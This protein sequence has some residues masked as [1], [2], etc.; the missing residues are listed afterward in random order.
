MSTTTTNGAPAPDAASDAAA[1][2]PTIV[3]AEDTVAAAKAAYA[4]L[5]AAE[6]DAADATSDIGAA[7][8]RAL[9]EG[10][11]VVLAPGRAARKLSIRNFESATGISRSTIAR[12]ARLAA[13]REAVPGIAWTVRD[14]DSIPADAFDKGS[15]RLTAKAAAEAGQFRTGPDAVKALRGVRA[16]RSDSTPEAK[17]SKQ[18]KTAAL[19]AIAAGTADAVRDT[20]A[21]AAKQASAIAEAVGIDG[22]A[23]DAA[24]AE[25]RESRAVLA[26]ATGST[27]PDGF[28]AA[29]EAIVKRAEAGWEFDNGSDEAR[30]WAAATAKAKRAVTRLAA[31]AKAFAEAKR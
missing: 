3:G 17:A 7:Y 19:E 2:A 21:D 31:A 23:S 10:K 22:R 29:V 15:G 9:R 14:A 16:P 12:G 28:A 24:K 1:F 25:A 11:G 13:L 5:Q 18:A 4:R 30:A 8:L 20:I 27:D 26:V 6:S